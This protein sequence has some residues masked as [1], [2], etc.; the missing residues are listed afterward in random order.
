MKKVF[1]P[2]ILCLIF[3]HY[4]ASQHYI[5]EKEFPLTAL[6][7][8]IRGKRGYLWASSFK[9]LIRYNGT[10]IKRYT[11]TNGFHSNNINDVE[12]DAEGN[13]WTSSNDNGLAIVK[14][15]TIVFYNKNNGLG[16]DKIK[17]IYR[18]QRQQMW[19]MSDIG[20]HV[21]QKNTFKLYPFQTHP[22]DFLWENSKG[23]LFFY[24]RTKVFLFTS[25]GFLPYKHLD[26]LKE[27]GGSF[28]AQSDHLGNTWF[29][30]NNKAPTIIKYDG[31]DFV[32]YDLST[33]FPLVN[34]LTHLTLG[35]R[36]QLWI[37]SDKG[38]IRL[39]LKT[40][41]F[42]HFAKKQGLTNNVVSYIYED[43]EHTLWMISRGALIK[44]GGSQLTVWN[45]KYG[46]KHP[47]VFAV[48]EDSSGHMWIGTRNGGVYQ[49]KNNQVSQIL[50]QKDGLPINVVQSLYKDKKRGMWIGTARGLV[51]YHQEKLKVYTRKDGLQSG[52][53]LDIKEN[54]QGH[55]LLAHSFG[56]TYYDR[57]KFT[58]IAKLREKTVWDILIDSKQ[59]VW[60][61]TSEGLFKKEK[62]T[63][64]HYTKEQ[65]LNSQ[66]ITCITEDY[67]GNLWLGSIGGGIIFY[68]HQKFSTLKHNELLSDNSTFGLIVHKPDQSLWAIGSFGFIKI[69]LENFY[70]SGKPT[71]KVI[72]KFRGAQGSFYLDKQNNFWFGGAGGVARYDP[73]AEHKASFYPKLQLESVSLFWEETKWSQYT[74]SIRHGIPYNLSLPHDQNHLVFSFS[75]VGFDL[76]ASKYQHKIAE[77]D[78]NWSIPNDKGEVSLRG[79]NPG[80]YTL[81]MRTQDFNGSWGKPL[82][83][84]F[85]IRPP[86]WQTLWFRTL[87][88]LA[89]L[90]SFFAILKWRSNKLTK[91][92]RKLEKLV[93]NRTNELQ[94]QKEELVRQ[95]E[96]LKEMDQVKSRFLSNVSHEL[97]TPLTLI[98]GPAEKL[99]DPKSKSWKNNVNTILANAKRLSR[100]INELLDFAKIEDG[101]MTLQ[102][103]VGKLN[104]FLQSLVNSFELLA[105]QKNIAL[106]LLGC[107]DELLY[108]FDQN[109]LDKVFFNLLSNAIKFTP[110]GG[111]VSVKLSQNQEA[112]SISIADTGI[113]I[114]EKALSLVF[115]RF[116]QVDGSQTR[117]QEGT[118]IG[119]A[120]AKEL[121]ELHQG[122][123]EVQSKVGQG[124]T[125]TVHLPPIMS[126]IS[127]ETSPT[128]SHE[129]LPVVSGNTYIQNDL[130][131]V[132][133]DSSKENTILVVE[134]NHDL[135]KFIIAELEESYNIIEASDGSEGIT[136]ALEHIPDFIISD[137]MMPKTDGLELL[138]TL[139]EHTTTHHIP[140]ILLTAKASPEN[141]ILGLKMGSDDYI[142][143]P[144]SP[145]ELRLRISN[146]LERRKQLWAAFNQE[147]TKVEVNPEPPKIKVSSL[148]KKFLEQA[149][150]LVE[151]HISSPD[152]DVAFFS[153]EIGLSK[154]SLFRKIKALTGM[155]ITE[156]IRNVRLKHAASLIKQKSGSMQE[157]AYEVGF[158]DVSYFNR[159]FK[160]LFGVTP[161]K[162][163]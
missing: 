138:K 68:D 25:Q 147:F 18:D 77:V 51:Y 6:N 84:S 134:D 13:I 126:K 145:E 133:G 128:L 127:Q 57:N 99:S 74:D 94:Q 162:Y 161:S 53:I 103:M 24:H 107:S 93:A 59:R 132:V 90:S 50:S 58:P 34:T 55:L 85:R 158:N 5:F 56:A 2:F 86:F 143:K 136:L 102:P 44:Y 27:F 9:G 155:S 41:K 20:V 38:L 153:S 146:M 46:L 159:C 122:S 35:H 22:L 28:Y 110:A 131:E 65:G 100:L 72:N 81:L 39:D 10:H 129:V 92:N 3:N 48:A 137:I 78:K 125:F 69:S 42:K 105:K 30:S 117:E 152:L 40:G 49:L 89:V 95:A 73:K 104:T 31:K 96:Q 142:T 21:W 101:K 109:K 15:D 64:T 11:T 135:R 12:Q 121:T 79:L 115:D 124:S 156:F 75:K 88:V 47:N 7:K 8:V 33:L 37:G 112:I 140:I 130:N 139:R 141:K 19:V 111:T 17:K 87:I 119:L 163:S 52:Q 61:A 144:F 62:D 1:G 98:I 149:I 82:R 36:N 26:K 70:K 60:F 154:S 106:E 76:Q 66:D 97:R 29:A 150:N 157:I 151:T 71:L 118:G 23:Q 45:N 83:Y 114:P 4:L 16:S 108:E 91:E 116:Y 67:K 43:K 120:L 113:G 80:N 54:A 148:D 123:I 160:K 63:W 32:S 14:P